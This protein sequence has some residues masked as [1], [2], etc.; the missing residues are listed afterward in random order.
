MSQQIISNQERNNKITRIHAIITNKAKQIERALP[1]G[2]VTADRMIRIV[3][4][5]I[6]QNKALW[7]C[8][9]ESLLAAVMQAAQLGLEPDG[10]LGMASLVPYGPKVQLVIGYRGYIQLA[11]RSGAVKDIRTR[12][13]FDGD[14][15]EVGYGLDET[16]THKPARSS[17]EEQIERARTFAQLSDSRYEEP[18]PIAVYGVAVFANGGHHFEVLWPEDIARIRNCSKAWQHPE[19]PWQKHTQAMWR[20]TAV[21]QTLKYCPMA[22][23]S[24]DLYRKFENVDGTSFSGIMVT[25][26]GEIVSEEERTQS[27]ASAVVPAQM[28]QPAPIPEQKPS[29]LDNFAQRAVE[30]EKKNRGRKPSAE[31][32][33][34]TKPEVAP[35]PKAPPPVEPRQT[36]L[37]SDQKPE[38][39]A[40][41]EDGAVEQPENEA[42]SAP[43][44]PDAST[45]APAPA[46]PRFGRKP[47]NK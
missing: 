37:F 45:E 6:S 1:R 44:E 39:V 41:D 20:K 34:V 26:D 3:L 42:A 23:E 18:D 24:A 35:T 21:K 8:S 19:S 16:L 40:A 5:A 25:D 43:E 15:F 11:L 46:R 4:T 22:S 38:E 28:E 7:Q 36:E 30:E 2:G 14:V 29:S 47:K 17:R 13:V 10:V 33:V 9:E 32:P 31:P 27:A 12:C